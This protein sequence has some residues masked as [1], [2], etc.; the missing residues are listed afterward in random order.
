MCDGHAVSLSEVA[1][2]RVAGRSAL[3]LVSLLGLGLAVAWS[4]LS[5]RAVMDVGGSCADGGPY[6]SA[7]P[8]PGGAGL[9][10]AAIPLM[11][12]SAFA[13]SFA[14]ATL[15]APNLLVPMWALLFGS[16]G[17]NFLD[18][19]FST[20]GGAIPAWIICGVVFELMAAPALVVIALALRRTIT[21]ASGAAPGV[22][23]WWLVYPVVGAAGVL[24]GIVTFAALT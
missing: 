18:Y 17:W 6:V 23:T 19:G 1:A 2:P 7:Q 13:G 16:L 20:D 12:V 21:S 3:L 9:I 5:M 14:A 24:L 4:Y 8:C 11:L 10:G 15:P 22:L